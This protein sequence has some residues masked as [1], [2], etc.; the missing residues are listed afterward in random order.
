MVLL[1]LILAQ[2]PVMDPTL[3][4]P[5]TALIYQQILW[6]HKDIYKTTW[7]MDMKL[8]GHWDIYILFYF[9]VLGGCCYNFTVYAYISFFFSTLTQVSVYHICQY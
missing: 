2:V 6:H 7:M 3:G 8:S 5:I 4:V 1:Y 9:L